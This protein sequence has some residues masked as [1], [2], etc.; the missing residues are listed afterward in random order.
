LVSS[1]SSQTKTR[2]QKFSARLFLNNFN[3]DGCYEALMDHIGWHRIHETVAIR[4]LS[5]V[6]KYLDGVRFTRERIFMV[7]SD[8]STRTSAKL[9]DKREN[10]NLQL[11]SNEEVKNTKYHK[12]AA[13]KLRVL[14]NALD[15]QTIDLPI[16]SFKEKT[17]E[18]LQRLVN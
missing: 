4:R 15:E 7:K 2:V 3:W 8:A 12:L 11:E 6:K 1:G 16:G 18:I 17:I 13:A 14:W 5:N 10:H 9:R